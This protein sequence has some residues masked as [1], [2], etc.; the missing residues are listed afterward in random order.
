[1]LR[2]GV[3]AWSGRTSLRPPLRPLSIL[4]GMR[5]ALGEPRCHAFESRFQASSPAIL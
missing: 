3:K 2:V 5:L 4:S 1:M